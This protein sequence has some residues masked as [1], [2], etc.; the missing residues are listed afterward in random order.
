MRQRA[1]VDRPHVRIETYQVS[2]DGE[3]V[4]A[5]IPVRALVA[6]GELLE[7]DFICGLLCLQWERGI[8]LAA[9]NQ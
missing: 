7:E 6:R 3:T 1:L 2:A 5:P 8:D 9:V 4:V